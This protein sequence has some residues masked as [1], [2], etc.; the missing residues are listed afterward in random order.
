MPNFQN[1]QNILEMDFSQMR[2]LKT[3]GGARA[4]DAAILSFVTNLVE[5]YTQ[6]DNM[7]T[8]AQ[9]ATYRNFMEQITDRINDSEHAYYLVKYTEE[10]PADAEIMAQTSKLK[11]FSGIP[12]RMQY[13]AASEEFGGTIRNAAMHRIAVSELDKWSKLL[14]S[15]RRDA[16]FQPVKKPDNESKANQ[17]PKN[18]SLCQ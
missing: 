7:P 10:C 8:H 5:F 11:S 4:T 18:Y 17:I 2:A 14:T 1:L 9:L 13:W 6:F 3:A 15:P 12:V 16:F